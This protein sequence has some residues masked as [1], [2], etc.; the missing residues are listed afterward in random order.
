MSEVGMSSIDNMP[1][2]M[3]MVEDLYKFDVLRSRPELAQLVE[4]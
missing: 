2:L 4:K 1:E 3:G